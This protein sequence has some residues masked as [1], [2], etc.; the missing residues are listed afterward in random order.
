[1]LVEER[2]IINWSGGTEIG[3]GILVGSP[4]VPMRECCFADH[5]PG[6]AADVFDAK[7]HSVV[8]EVGELVLTRPW[9]SMTR[10]LW[11]DPERYL[12]TYWSRWP[13]VWLHGDR[14]M[15]Y[16]DGSWE[17]LG[18][19]DD[20]LK[21]AGKRLWPA[22]VESVVTDSNEIIMAAAVGIPDPIRGEVLALMKVPSLVARGSDPDGHVNEPGSSLHKAPSL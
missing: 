18:R 4:M 6:M 7:G 3:C 5:A 11:L 10:G 2:F 13:G 17:L 12:E 1:M 19:S 9:P 8:G 21:I 14:A 16:D 22:E 20:V 15:R